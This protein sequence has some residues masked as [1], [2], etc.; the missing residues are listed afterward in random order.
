MLFVLHYCVLISSTLVASLASCVIP[1]GLEDLVLHLGGLTMQLLEMLLSWL[2][3]DSD[4]GWH[5]LLNNV[6]PGWL[7]VQLLDWN[8]SLLKGLLLW[9]LHARHTLHMLKLLNW[10]LLDYRRKIQIVSLLKLSLVLNL[11]LNL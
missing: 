6:L 7:F 4:L 1:W 10:L 11:M 2:W 8:H 9:D 5:L 3:L